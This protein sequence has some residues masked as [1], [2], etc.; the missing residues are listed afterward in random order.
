MS[1]SSASIGVEKAYS[2]RKAAFSFSEV[3][4]FPLLPLRIGIDRVLLPLPR[5][6][7]HL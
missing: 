2:L 4:V 3:V 7:A 6:L 5:L 1:L